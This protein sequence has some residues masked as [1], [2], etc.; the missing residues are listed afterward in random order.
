MQYNINILKEKTIEVVYSIEHPEII[1]ES[2]EKSRLGTERMTHQVI[3]GIAGSIDGYILDHKYELVPGNW[4]V[5]IRYK[6]IE[7]S[8]KHLKSIKGI[9]RL[10][11][12]ADK[13]GSRWHSRYEMIGEI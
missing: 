2:G 6:G 11:R 12:I 13:P 7:I 10:H 9:K 8:R 5:S 4:K 1:L 3:D